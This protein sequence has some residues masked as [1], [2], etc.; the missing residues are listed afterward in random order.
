[1]DRAGA[2]VGDP[3]AG[4]IC[5]DVERTSPGHLGLLRLS[6]FDWPLGRHQ[7]QDP[8]DE[9][10]GIWLP[11]PGVLQTQD[12][13]PSRNKTRFSRMSPKEYERKRLKNKPSSKRKY[14]CS[15]SRMAR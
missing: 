15:R 8:T 10:S 6:D 7:Y 3:D 9:T 12:L 4:A 2:S 1:L 13:R 11:R 14:E 5:R